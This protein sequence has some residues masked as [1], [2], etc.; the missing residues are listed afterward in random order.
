LLGPFGCRDQPFADGVEVRPFGQ[1]VEQSW[2]A[3][4]RLELGQSAGNGRLAQP[5]RTP[6][7]AQ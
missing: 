7:G 5:E 4:R 1:P 2:S 3:E 6:R